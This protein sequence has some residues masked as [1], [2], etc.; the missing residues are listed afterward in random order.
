LLKSQAF[1]AVSERAG[2]R[3]LWLQIKPQLA[4]T[5]LGDVRRHVAY[6]LNYY[7]HGRLPEC[8]SQPRPFRVESDPPALLGP[9]A[10]R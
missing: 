3:P 1:P 7:S 2:V 9:G 5:C 6:G 10:K 8:S 4:E